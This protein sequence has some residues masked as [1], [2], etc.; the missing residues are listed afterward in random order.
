MK[1]VECNLF[2]VIG[3]QAISS[4]VATIFVPREK[5][6]SSS[7]GTGAPLQIFEHEIISGHS[8]GPEGASPAGVLDEAVLEYPQASTIFWQVTPV[9]TQ[10]GSLLQLQ[11]KKEEAE[12]EETAESATSTEPSFEHKVKASSSEVAESASSFENAKSTSDHSN[13]GDTAKKTSFENSGAL[14]RANALEAELDKAGVNE[15]KKEVLEEAALKTDGKDEKE[16]VHLKGNQAGE[17]KSEGKEEIRVEGNIK[18]E[19]LDFENLLARLRHLLSAS[20]GKELFDRLLSV[21][22]LHGNTLFIGRAAVALM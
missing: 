16:S 11:S 7:V 6:L 22:D 3:L 14:E 17:A 4:A 9:V 10:A 19:P 5:S 2:A 1:I 13:K 15:R 8:S 18:H 12:P 21:I 20:K